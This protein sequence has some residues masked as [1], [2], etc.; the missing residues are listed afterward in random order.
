VN[1]LSQKY[2]NQQREFKVFRINRGLQEKDFHPTSKSKFSL[3]LI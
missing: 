1:N 3:G 2:K